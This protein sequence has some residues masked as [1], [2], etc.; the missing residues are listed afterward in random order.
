MRTCKIVISRAVPGNRERHDFEERLAEELASWGA[1]VVLVPDVYQLPRDEPCLSSLRRTEE[2]LVCFSWLQPRAAF[3]TLAE[4]GVRGER[5]EAFERKDARGGRPIVCFNLQDRSSPE[6]WLDKVEEL[7]DGNRPGG[8]GA[9]SRLEATPGER[10]YPVIDYERCTN[11]LECLEFCLFG[12]Y[13][14]DEEGL[15]VAA[16]PDACKPGCPACSRV[17]PSQAIMFPF[18]E[19]PAI[20]GSDDGAIKPFDPSAIE[21][22]KEDYVRGSI[23]LSDMVRRCLCEKGNVCADGKICDCNCETCE[24]RQSEDRFDDL[25]DEVVGE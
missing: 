15:L 2:P 3:W 23:A 25:I 4:L 5:V 9:L 14:T 10:W 22:L 18:S 17:C 21:K 8:R 1:D 19:D 16:N 11:C 13:D 12:V 6:G 7:L 20:A 24:R